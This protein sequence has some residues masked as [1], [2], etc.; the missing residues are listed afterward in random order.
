MLFMSLMSF[1]S[2]MEPKLEIFFI[3]ILTM[4]PQLVLLIKIHCGLGD[5]LFEQIVI[6]EY[7]EVLYLIILIFLMCSPNGVF[8]IR[9]YKYNYEYS[10]LK[11]QSG[12]D[13]K[14]KKLLQSKF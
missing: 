13:S 12:G 14:N 3:H 5:I 2:F 11:I 7:T 4:K 8:F 1:V 9:G 10:L 6:D